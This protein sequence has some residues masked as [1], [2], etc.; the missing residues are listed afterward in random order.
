M[1]A[2][3][4]AGDQEASRWLDDLLP[5]VQKIPR[6]RAEVLCR[7]AQVAQTLDDSIQLLKQAEE[8]LLV[9]SPTSHLATIRG[10]LG[11]RLLDAGEVDSA[12]KVLDQ[13]KELSALLNPW[14][15]ACL[16]DEYAL[17]ARVQ[18][19]FHSAI[20][21]Y[22]RSYAFFIANGD[23]GDAAINRAG[24][25]SAMKSMGDTKNSSL[26]SLD[27]AMHAMESADWR[28]AIDQWI[29]AGSCLNQLGQFQE[30]KSAFSTALELATGESDADYTRSAHYGLVLV[31]A[32]L[33]HFDASKY[34]LGRFLA[35][36]DGDRESE[37]FGKSFSDWLNSKASE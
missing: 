14:Q 33:R 7:L 21:L 8:V 15:R 27:A 1:L 28:L 3:R 10:V 29:D 32:H 4:S 18:G 23:H 2:A 6:W 25:A 19:D 37:D 12:L 16:D 17:A 31:E 11:G 9:G 36:A 34:H 30:A 20:M 22:N 24:A 5:A 35:L 13:A 26:A